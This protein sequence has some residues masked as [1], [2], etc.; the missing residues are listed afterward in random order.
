MPDLSVTSKAWLPGCHASR[1]R[2]RVRSNTA[3][4]PLTADFSVSR[5]TRRHSQGSH[6]PTRLASPRLASQ[7]PCCTALAPSRR[8]VQAIHNMRA[9]TAARAL[10]HA[11]FLAGF[12]SSPFATPSRQRHLK[13]KAFPLFLSS[14]AIT[15]ATVAASRISDRDGSAKSFSSRSHR[16]DDG[17]H[18]P[19][20]V[21][22][23]QGASRGIG[24]EFV[25][26]LQFY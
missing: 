26:H 23:V 11:S 10:R 14:P 21:S 19:S 1:L 12:R 4:R 15:S 9:S 5:E 3:P 7:P 24:L 13:H 2:H 17:G 16:N 18:A 6:L 25:S 20:T 22:V 8:E